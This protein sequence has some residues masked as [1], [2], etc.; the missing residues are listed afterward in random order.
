MNYPNSF[1]DLCL[2]RKL[3]VN[4]AASS[5]FSWIGGN[6]I[7]SSEPIPAVSTITVGPIALS[8]AAALVGDYNIL[9]FMQPKPTVQASVENFI[10]SL[11]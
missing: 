10:L 2:P 4:G 7:L 11:C 5:T 8:S 3:T 6:F 9:L 1:P